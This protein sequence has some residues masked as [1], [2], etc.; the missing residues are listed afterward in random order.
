MSAT[1]TYRLNV[2]A[3]QPLAA[4]EKDAEERGW[5]YPNTGIR[6]HARSEAQHRK[7]RHGVSAPL[8][9]GVRR[10]T[11]GLHGGGGIAMPM[12][13]NL[14]PEDEPGYIDRRTGPKREAPAICFAC[15]R[16]IEQPNP[17]DATCGRG[18]CREAAARR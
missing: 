6:R 10:R 4:N 1:M 7:G 14:T 15:G 8:R 16:E 12:N 11:D 2:W 13:F 17:L 9:A 18:E 5:D 3:K